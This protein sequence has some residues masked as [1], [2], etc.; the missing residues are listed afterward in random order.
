MKKSALLQQDGQ[1]ASR[2]VDNIRGNRVE[3]WGQDPVQGQV[4][5]IGPEHPSNSRDTPP[6]A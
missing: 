2:A 4:A 1:C 3:S 6:G 5:K